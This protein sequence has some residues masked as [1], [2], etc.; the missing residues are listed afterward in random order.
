MGFAILCVDDEAII[1]LSLKNELRMALGNK[2]IYESAMNALEAKNKIEILVKD[3]ID[4]ILI[5]SDW[6]MPGMKGDEFL[7][8]IHKKYPKI[9]SIMITGHADP[10]S[11]EKAK[12]EANLVAC[13][14]KPWNNKELI[15]IVK[16]CL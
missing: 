14:S 12:K 9:K 11:I 8:E 6:L 3:G 2:Y 5:I 10:E 4:I 15:D 1:L 7:I 13:L 16:S